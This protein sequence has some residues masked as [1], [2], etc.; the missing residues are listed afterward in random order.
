MSNKFFEGTVEYFRGFEDNRDMG[1]N[2]P[3]GSDT[4]NKIENDQGHYVANFYPD[5]GHQE[6]IDAGIPNKGL[7][8]QLFKTDADGREFYKLKRKHFNPALTD[9]ETGEKGIVQG[10][11]Y[12]IVIEDGEKRDWDQDKDGL[13]GN[14]SRVQVKVNVWQDKIVTWVATKVVDL[15][16]YNPE[17][18]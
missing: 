11:P 15:V 13:I 6:L 17:G 10:P 7:L 16:E 9:R 4:R 1:Q 14:G 8:G 18:F 2:L 3:E 12:T 5:G